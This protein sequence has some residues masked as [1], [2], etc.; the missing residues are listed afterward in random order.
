MQLSKFL[1]QKI[2]PLKGEV[3]IKI[4]KHCGKK[5]SCS[6]NQEYCSDC[7]TQEKRLK[8]DEVKNYKKMWIEIP[9]NIS[10]PYFERNCDTCGRPYKTPLYTDTTHVQRHCPEHRNEYKR[11]LY[12]STK[13]I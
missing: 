9:K 7:T 11:K 10:S 13:C 5:M 3:F 4:C 6:R 2:K 8:F 12:L 1:K